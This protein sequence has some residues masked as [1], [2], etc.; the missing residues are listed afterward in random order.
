ME[1]TQVVIG[2][3]DSQR[4]GLVV[5]LQAEHLTLRRRLWR[6]IRY[7]AATTGIGLL[8]ANFLLLLFPIPHLHI[9]SIPLA[10][11][12][13]PLV[14][15]FTFRTRVLLA[16]NSVP[17]PK[18]A[19]PVTVPEKLGGWPARFNCPHCAIMIELSAAR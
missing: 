16:S 6:A 5:T 14:A 13:G 2:R 1:P 18:C 9:C 10:I 15:I 17:C 8:I 11:L 12:L 19:T 3:M 7:G 4:P